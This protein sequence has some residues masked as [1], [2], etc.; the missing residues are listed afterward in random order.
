M[1]ELIIKEITEEKPGAV[2]KLQHY[3]SLN[4]NPWSAKMVADAIANIED[5]K[6]LGEFV[7]RYI[8]NACHKCGSCKTEVVNYDPLWRD[9]DV[10][11]SECKEHIRFYNAG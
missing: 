8:A 3:Y 4:E 7:V 2:L 6:K 5:I 10:V 1:K 9:G 11:C